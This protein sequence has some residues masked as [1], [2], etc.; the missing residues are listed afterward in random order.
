MNFI[1]GG[2]VPLISKA[3]LILLMIFLQTEASAQKGGGSGSVIRDTASVQAK[4][5]T[6]KKVK[7][8]SLAVIH[9]G[10]LFRFST[11][12]SVEQSR[13]TV[14]RNVYDL[15]ERLPFVYRRNQGFPG[16]WD[17]LLQ[18][19]APGRFSSLLS[20]GLPARGSGAGLANLNYYAAEEIDSL[21]QV[22]LSRAFLYGFNSGGSVINAVRS[23]RV[24]PAPITRIRYW[25][26]TYDEAQIE[27]LFS[28]QLMKRMYISVMMKNHN[29]PSS[30]RRSSSS[31][32]SGT[33]DLSYYYSNNLQLFFRYGFANTLTDINGGVNVDTLKKLGY[34]VTA[35][36]YDEFA[37]PVT[38]EERYYKHKENSYSA[39]LRHK[40][41]FGTTTLKY[42]NTN[43]LF[44]YRLNEG[45]KDS[46]NVKAKDDYA[47]GLHALLLK[48]STELFSLPAELTWHYYYNR[49]K[50][51]GSTMYGTP[52][53]AA[54][55]TLSLISRP[56]T[57]H[58]AVFGKFIRYGDY[59]YFGAGADLFVYNEQ[60]TSYFGFSYY[61]RQ[62]YLQ[63]T[64]D[65]A[66]V[67]QGEFR[68]T[69]TYDGNHYSVHGYLKRTSDSHSQVSINPAAGGFSNIPVFNAL[70]TESEWG[71]EARA[72]LHYSR[73][74]T[75]LKMT[76]Q[77]SVTLSNSYK[78]LPE[79]Q[80]SA[81][82]SYRNIHFDSSL[83][84]RGG[85]ILSAQSATG[86]FAYL[87]PSL[88]AVP[89]NTPEKVPAFFRADA[90]F[91]GEIKRAAVVFMVIEN[92]LNAGYYITPYYPMRGVNY[93]FGINWQLFN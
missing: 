62:P 38:F 92:L 27:A 87:Y 43:G 28:T 66:S 54:T 67:L 59:N 81:D 34:D 53:N 13:Y 51:N 93:R 8:D 20:G 40:S 30:Y 25:E 86:S 64:S 24:P 80:G 16:Q 5:T 26:G 39:E 73:I 91:T 58:P 22:P 15:S 82:I 29:S 32:W 79:L 23:E 7:R 41:E 85:V 83:V 60:G 77:H 72:E 88:G 65:A 14:F 74:Y 49:Y 47:S 12:A 3:V 10:S 1:S 90:Y 61:Q 44:E 42:L 78:L 21:E 50:N 70:P 35:Y 11:F 84:F 68:I 45:L 48:H 18:F 17:E 36:L 19:A 31:V 75:E 52:E 55:F 89:V 4:D 57:H 37:A 9:S 2:K 33:A 63:T 56:T 76:H 6:A 46:G 69:R 71:L